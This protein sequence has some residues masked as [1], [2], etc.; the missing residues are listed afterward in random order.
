MIA[1]LLCALTCGVAH[2]DDSLSPV[3]VIS[4][5]ETVDWALS[6]SSAPKPLVFGSATAWA[7]AGPDGLYLTCFF[8]QGTTKEKL[9]Q[10]LKTLSDAA[11][12]GLKAQVTESKLDPG[13]TAPGGWTHTGETWLSLRLRFPALKPGDMAGLE[14]QLQKLSTDAG[15][16]HWE[17][18]TDRTAPVEAS[19]ALLKE[20]MAGARKMAEA[21]AKAAGVRLGGLH[22]LASCDLAPQGSYYKMGSNIPPGPQA[23]RRVGVEVWAAWE[24]LPPG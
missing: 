24:L 15:A 11:V 8:A 2:A 22:S 19:E 5:T 6:V 7:D 10:T 12:A 3:Q 18:I 20:A 17:A 13:V 14:E 16:T 23:S 9:Q 4:R 21:A 1:L